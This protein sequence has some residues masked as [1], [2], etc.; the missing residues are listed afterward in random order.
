M[1]IQ[2]YGSYNDI[3]NTSLAAIVPAY[4]A[5]MEDKM[6]MTIMREC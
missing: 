1:L 2:Q 6:L 4:V 5:Y 3:Q